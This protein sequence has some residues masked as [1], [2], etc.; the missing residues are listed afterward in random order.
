[1]RDIEGNQVGPFDQALIN[2]YYGLRL[3]VV[4]Q[5]LGGIETIPLQWTQWKYQPEKYSYA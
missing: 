3:T 4:S 5:L 1:M 2:A